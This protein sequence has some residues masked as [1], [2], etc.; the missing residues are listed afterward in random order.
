MRLSSAA[1]GEG[2]GV[3]SYAALPLLFGR[4]AKETVLV[5]DEAVDDRCRSG[6]TGEDVLDACDRFTFFVGGCWV[7][8]ATEDLG[9]EGR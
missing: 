4:S 7:S 5:E 9:T 6:E 3:C 1:P 2:G 8:V